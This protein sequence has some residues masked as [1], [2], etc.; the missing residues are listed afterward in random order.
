[1]LDHAR[2]PSAFRTV[3]RLLADP[4]AQCN[5]FPRRA[6]MPD[7]LRPPS[8]EALQNAMDAFDDYFRVFS[9]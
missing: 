1:M 6:G 3:D 4:Q 2:V 5:H 7:R 9:S 8:F